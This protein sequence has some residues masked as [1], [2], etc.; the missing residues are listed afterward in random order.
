MPVKVRCRQCEKVFA[1][2]D[3]ARGKAVR[4]PGCREPVK[5]PTGKRKQ[6]GDASE[7]ESS[8][9]LSVFSSLDLSQAEDKRARLCP[10]CA[11]E[12]S[13]ED[14]I[15]PHC[16]INLQTGV[17]SSRMQKRLKRKGPNPVLFY[18]AAWADSW[19]FML[20]NQRL[21]IQTWIVT[22]GVAL[23]Q[24]GMVFVAFWIVVTFLPKVTTE[25]E[26]MR[27]GG[28]GQEDEPYKVPLLSQ[29]LLADGFQIL[30]GLTLLLYM[31]VTGWIWTMAVQIT[32]TTLARKTQAKRLA[33]QFV[34]SL[35][36]GFKMYFWGVI[37]PLPVM[38][39]AAPLMM[40]LAVGA[41]ALS[42]GNMPTGAALMAIPVLIIGGIVNLVILLSIPSAL[43][44]M[45]QKHT[46][47][48]WSLPLMAF[49]AVRNIAPTLYLALI[50][51]VAVI[52]PAAVFVGGIAVVQF[53]LREAFGPPQL[54]AWTEL[55]GFN[56]AAD[57]AVEGVPTF[58]WKPVG[59]Y[60]VTVIIGS[61]VGAYAMIFWMRAVG[62]F[63]YYYQQRLGLVKRTLP[64]ELAGFWA[65]YIAV[66]VDFLIIAVVGWIFEPI[67]LW[68]MN[69]KGKLLAVLMIG[70]AV[71]FI[72]QYG[73]VLGI[74]L[75][76]LALLPFCGFSY[77]ARMESDKGQATLGK[78]AVGIMVTGPNG[79][80]LTFAQSSLRA[81]MKLLLLKGSFVAGFTPKKQALHDMV[82]GTLVVF[83]GDL[84]RE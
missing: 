16:H 56:G 15:C 18:K 62:L 80:K 67:E 68:K 54:L 37:F 81:I 69:E 43:A 63:A 65:R 8:A 31:I 12:V 82:A 17:V 66:L 2:P 6:S 41:T 79:E 1:A 30:S 33:F 34:D 40:L 76:Y 84:D 48:A 27:Q 57:G 75:G 42:A 45:A 4:C 58:P 73:F 22:T 61:L 50:G 74:G 20:S 38:I 72:S 23:L 10:K 5:V 60:L 59:G 55:I 49:T 21:A 25:M 14:R 39:I 11:S 47:K 83:R 28:A 36:N 9:D 51:L 26:Q 29:L 77:F 7:D 71:F 70:L 19:R 32:R 24:A 35:A 13:T 3:R 78:E 44:H 46:Y 64:G 53:G 52:L